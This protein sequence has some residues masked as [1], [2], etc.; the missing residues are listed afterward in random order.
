MVF[1]FLSTRQAFILFGLIPILGCLTIYILGLRAACIKRRHMWEDW[2]WGPPDQPLPFE[3]R[4]QLCSCVHLD[5][6]IDS[7]H[8]HLRNCHTF[9]ERNPTKTKKDL[10]DLP[11]DDGWHNWRIFDFPLR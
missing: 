1:S 7:V 11:T 8:Y 3:E 2:A 9:W 10:Q 6:A 5:D 4:W